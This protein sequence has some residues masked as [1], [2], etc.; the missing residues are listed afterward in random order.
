MAAAD[1]MKSKVQS[2]S[3]CSEVCCEK[4]RE[5]EKSKQPGQQIFR[6]LVGK[7][8][9]A[10]VDNGHRRIGAIDVDS[11]LISINSEG[12]DS[13]KLHKCRQ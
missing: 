5:I 3:V 12:E 13:H 2:A 11:T 9:Q 10:K 4:W 1:A 6:S 7:K 8:L